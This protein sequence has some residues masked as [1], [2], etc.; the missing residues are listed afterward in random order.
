MK[1]VLY[2]VSC[3]IVAAGLMA[4]AAFASERWNPFQ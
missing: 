1:R 3:A 4:A 2:F